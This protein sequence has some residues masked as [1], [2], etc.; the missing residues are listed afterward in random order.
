MNKDIYIKEYFYI[1][2]NESA[3]EIDI[4]MA[5]FMLFNLIKYKFSFN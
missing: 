2:K 5:Y 3:N 4:I 1:L